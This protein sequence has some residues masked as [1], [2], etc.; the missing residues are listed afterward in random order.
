MKAII[1]AGGMA[2]RLRP[3]TNDLPKCLLNVGGK[4]I[5]DRQIESLFTEGVEE[6]IVVTGFK[7]ELL[8]QHIRLQHP[9]KDIRAVKNE[10]YESTGPAYGL[11]CVKEY[12]GESEVLY[13]NGDLVCDHAVIKDLIASS[14]RSS[15]A[16]S[17][18][19]WDKEQ[20]KI[21]IHPDR[22]VKALGKW[23]GA[24]HSYGEFVGATKI[25]KEFGRSLKKILEELHQEGTL[26]E[27]FAADALHE[28]AVRGES[29]SMYIHDVTNYR[30]MEIDTIS[31]FKE[32]RNMWQ[33]KTISKIGTLL[34]I[35]VARLIHIASYVFPRSAKKIVFIG[36]HKNEEREIFAD[37]S[38]YLF[39][40][41]HHGYKDSIRPIWIAKD[42]QIAAIL[43][44]N[45]MEAHC[46]Y[47]IAGIW[48]ALTSKRTVVD[49]HMYRNNWQFSGGSRVVQLWHGKGM[50]KSGLVQKGGLGFSKF[51]SPE[52]FQTFSFLI[53]SSKY[54][55][56]LM[57]DIF[58]VPPERVLVTGLPRNDTLYQNI[59]G[60]DIDVDERYTDTIAEFKKEGAKKIIAYM[61]TFRRNSSNPLDQLDLGK[62]NEVLGKN[63]FRMIITLHP[64]FSSNRYRA[65][66]T[67]KNIRIMEAGYDIYP[68]F[69]N[70][71]MLITDYSS[72]Y[73][74]YLLLDCPIIF[75]TYD[76]ESYEKE[77]GL[78][79]DF[80][81]LAP[82]PH[83]R[84]FDELLA[85]ISSY[86]DADWKDARRKVTDK[87]HAFRDGGAGDRIMKE[88][89]MS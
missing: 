85:A 18:N 48:H 7:S 14:K 21:G 15:T 83:V 77:T 22:S 35:V 64:K 41:A 70:I 4:T 47:S 20:V 68:L 40:R 32:A 6:I 43:K 62:T 56:A 78:Y 27:R 42:K 25:S 86:K 12:L 55:A 50:K 10:K 23:V 69:K 80:D 17:R 38:K 65:S 53:A 36:W 54:T 87:L 66:N 51:V 59:P 63:N 49:A 2:R 13:L 39:L 89:F 28:T 58:K 26:A 61:P 19:P 67:L 73:V 82:G 8:E 37:N 57:A 9:G 60:S 74:D 5:L 29:D 45:G 44:Q 24:L 75:Y 52:L 71:D 33:K 76:R 88:I 31:D 30:T 81:E 1:L 79:E 72:L 84:T 46:T 3:I 16:V 11:W 34:K